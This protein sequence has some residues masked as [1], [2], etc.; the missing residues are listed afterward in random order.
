MVA[1]T[2][3]AF[4]LMPDDVVLPGSVEEAL[5]EHPLVDS[6]GVVGIHDLVHGENV[7]AYV[8]FKEGAVPPSS[9]DL[10]RFARELIG[11]KAPEEIVV[12]KSMP[13]NATGK[14]DRVSLKRMAEDLHGHTSTQA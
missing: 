5:L 7:R 9:Q 8:T 14:V 4:E 12:L 6:V 3:R 10:M 13:L 11:Y 2:A 1:S